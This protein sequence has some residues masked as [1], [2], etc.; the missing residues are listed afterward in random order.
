M[1]QHVF[2]RLIPRVVGLSTVIAGLVLAPT[3][4]AA[5]APLIKPT[6]APRRILFV[7]N[8]YS[9]YNNGIHTHLRRLIEA[10]DPKEFT[11]YELRTLALTSGYMHE[12]L[13]LLPSVLRLRKWD[14]VVLQA[15]SSE[16]MKSDPAQFE[17]FLGAV[18]KCATLVRASGARPVL[19]MTMAY[20]DKPEM[21]AALAE[22]YLT[23]GNELQAL[24]VPVGYAF[25]SARK[26]VPGLGLHQ[27]DK[28]HPNFAGTYLAACTFYGAFFQRSPLGISYRGD[29]DPGIAASLQASA[30]GT[31]E[32]FYGLRPAR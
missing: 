13:E 1:L 20:E 31:V 6:D 15:Q 18:R 16:P 7:G 5:V 3:S 9:L 25:E 23:A 10:A 32:A 30:W 29:L 17:R 19:F 14:V 28:T 22:G 8:S 24:V 2:A 4:G 27:P 11:N 26:E 21:T 12:L